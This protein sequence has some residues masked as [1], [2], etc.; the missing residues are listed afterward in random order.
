MSNRNDLSDH[1][2]LVERARFAH[3]AR[4]LA[5]SI[6][7]MLLLGQARGMDLQQIYDAAW[8][9]DATLRAARA[10]A[11]AGRERLPQARAQQLPSIA[12]SIGR[13]MNDL[14]STTPNA[15]GVKQTIDTRY[16]SS[17]E[18]LTLRQPLF[19]PVLSA[20]VK[21]AQAQVEDTEAALRL[22]EQTFAAR[23]AVAYF[24]AALTKEQLE[25]VTTQKAAYQ[26]QLDASRKSF[27]AGAGTRT[28][29]DEAQARLDITL[30]QEI[31]ARQNRRYTLQQ[32][33]V[34]VNQN[35]DEVASIN[36][37]R[38][39]L[40]P[41]APND[42]NHW[43]LRAE[44]RSPQLQSLTAQ[45]EV[46]RQ[47][48]EKANAGHYPTLDAVAQWSRSSSENVTNFRNKYTNTTLGLQLGIPI[49]SG[50]L[51][52]SQVRQALALQERAEQ[53][54]EAAR[55]DLGLRV[56]KEY[57]GVAEGVPKIKALEQSLRSS[58]QLVLSSKKSF[59]A[60]SRTVLDILNAEQQRSV[61]QR[62]LAQARYVYLISSIRL[63][64]LTGD[65]DASMIA[66]INAA[67]KP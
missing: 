40:N 61:V 4:R 30:A 26:Q 23:L 48:V 3:S 37:A 13:N 51:V 38:L 50:G 56:F 46:A 16:P 32:L 42:I 41:P 8:Q 49:F 5:A 18:T 43:T 31:E 36:A 57:R 21:Q 65:A 28:D 52:Q 47:E 25:L 39:E 11:A 33:E 20:Q 63:L 7:F 64:A 6:G 44:L 54:L 59:Q 34:L 9:Q 2:A 67:L 60:G 10:T 62:D 27:A 14:S 24:E 45:L 12:A 22:E 29:I 1:G 66:S 35:V 19:R 55:R 17:N 53:I 58:E 15:V